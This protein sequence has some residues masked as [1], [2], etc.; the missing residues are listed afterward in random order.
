VSPIQASYDQL[1]DEYYDA[2]LHPTCANFREGSKALIGEWL[3]ASHRPTI[4]EIGAGKSIVV[5]VAAEEERLDPISLVL[6]DESVRMLRHSNTGGSFVVADACALPTSA[7]FE[8]IVASLGDPYN[9]PAF[10]GEVARA[11]EPGADV[12]FTTPSYEW[13]TTFRDPDAAEQA[14]FVTTSG[15]HVWIP[16]YIASASD[17][18]A[19]GRA[20]GLRLQMKKDFYATELSGPLSPKLSASAQHN[21]PI[22]TGYWFEKSFS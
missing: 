17:Q 12:F 2:E 8:V 16:S 5:E 9:V 21:D 1:A 11:C 14:D 18:A 3:T 6:V 19:M 4:C 13:A 15:E 20:V 22:V 7:T 10:W